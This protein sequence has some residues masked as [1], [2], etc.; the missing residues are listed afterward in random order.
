MT[1]VAQQTMLIAL[2]MHLQRGIDA[3]KSTLKHQQRAKASA[4]C[5]R[6]ALKRISRRVLSAAF[7]QWITVL[8]SRAQE[9][10][11]R[12]QAIKRMHGQALNA[13]LNQWKAVQDTKAR[14]CT[15]QDKG[16]W[17][18]F[19]LVV[20]AAL[21]QLAAVLTSERLRK[22]REVSAYQIH[23]A[24]QRRCA[25]VVW[26]AVVLSRLC[27][28]RE[29]SAY[30]IHL[31]H[32]QRCVLGV[33]RAVAVSQQTKVDEQ[34]LRAQCAQAII[35][36]SDKAVAAAFSLWRV[37]T[38]YKWQKEDRQRLGRRLWRRFPHF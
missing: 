9:C 18:R 21:R 24:Q 32:Q 37:A 29:V 33:W 36:T 6:K 15:A 5:L 19:G 8:E 20:T 16:T 12:D 4:K 23:L 25:L 11:A 3:F 10:T 31:A 28:G 13:A 14:E 22:G 35:R 30:Q 1:L 27:K 2:D 17:F 26:R 7:D 38:Q 34:L